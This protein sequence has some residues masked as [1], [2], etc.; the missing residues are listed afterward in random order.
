ME[1]EIVIKNLPTPHPKGPGPDSFRVKIDQTF[2][3]ANTNTPQIIPL[4]RNRKNTT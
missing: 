2:K 3:R 4:N 1:M